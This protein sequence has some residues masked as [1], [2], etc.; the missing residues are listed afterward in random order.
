MNIT[1]NQ[2]IKY[3]KTIMNEIK[4]SWYDPDKRKEVPKKLGLLEES[5][6]M[7]INKKIDEIN[8]RSPKL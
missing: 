7:F 6:N 4:L 5:I 8:R 1:Q 3:F 2:T